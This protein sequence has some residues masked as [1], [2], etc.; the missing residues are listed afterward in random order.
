METNERAKGAQYQEAEQELLKLLQEVEG[1]LRRRSQ[2]V[3]AEDLSRNLQNRPEGHGRQDEERARVRAS[4]NQAARGMWTPANIGELPL[5][6]AVNPERLGRVEEGVLSVPSGGR[7]RASR[8]G[9][10]GSEVFS[11]PR[12]G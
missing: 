4:S 9:R 11:W 7:P 8:R 1:L 2:R 5:E 10:T 3:R 6:K 12:P